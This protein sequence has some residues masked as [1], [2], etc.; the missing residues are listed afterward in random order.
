MIPESVPDYALLL[1]SRLLASHLA[2]LGDPNVNPA[3]KTHRRMELEL[4][5]E[6]IASMSPHATRDLAR[7]FDSVFLVTEEFPG[8]LSAHEWYMDFLSGR[9]EEWLQEVST[10][11]LARMW[12]RIETSPLRN[13]T[14][15]VLLLID[16]AQSS[17]SHQSQ[18][19]RLFA[20]LRPAERHSAIE[21]LSEGQQAIS[22]CLVEEAL[23]TS[24][25]ST[26]KQGRNIGAGLRN[27][28]ID[29][30]RKCLGSHFGMP[31]PVN[32]ANH[33]LEVVGELGEP[34][35]TEIFMRLRLPN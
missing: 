3:E 12:W 14:L 26:T 31:I 21:G 10:D 23:A 22:R 25:E 13:K 15:R 34:L 6:S 24:R 27:F 2:P 20:S 29:L 7:S 18:I 9:S 16:F 30:L 19:E 33:A 28:S 17:G 35:H 4:Q 8:I 1:F 11:R 5:I 32:A